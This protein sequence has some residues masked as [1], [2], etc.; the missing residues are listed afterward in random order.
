VKASDQ[1]QT[2]VRTISFK[3][4]RETEDNVRDADN[5][6]QEEDGDVKNWT[7]FVL[8]TAFGPEHC[9]LPV[10]VSKITPNS[11]AA[12]SGLNVGDIVLKLNGS[13]IAPYAHETTMKAL[14]TTL[15]LKRPEPE[16]Q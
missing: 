10:V 4:P 1:K 2:V 8:G 16:F 6:V 7:E 12:Q 15:R 3:R 14:V 13:S 5:P 11:V 9:C